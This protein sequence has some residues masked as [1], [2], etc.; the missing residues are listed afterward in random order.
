MRRV[1]RIIRAVKVSK[2]FYFL[3]IRNGKRLDG[4]NACK[5]VK[6]RV[7]V[8]TCGRNPRSAR[9]SGFPLQVLLRPAVVVR[10]FRFNPLRGAKGSRFRP[11]TGISLKG[12]VFEFEALLCSER[13]TQLFNAPAPGYS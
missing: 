13:F 5:T 11:V 10:A 7:P 3:F 12:S 2:Y 9:R 8:N 1:P 4:A 6:G